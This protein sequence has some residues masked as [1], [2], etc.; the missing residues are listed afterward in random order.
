MLRDLLVH[1]DGSP[2]GRRRARFALELGTRMG[3]QLTG[4]HVT[5][6]AEAP[7][8]YKPSVVVT[9]VVEIARRLALDAAEA[10]TIFQE[11]I[12]PHMPGA[13]WIAGNGDVVDGVCAQARYSDLVI[14]GQYEEEGSPERHPLPVAHSIVV[15]CGRPVLVIPA[16]SETCTFAKVAIA[17]DRGR[18]AV[19]AVHD[20]LPLLGLAHSVD[21]VTVIDPTAAS[22]QLSDKQLAQHLAHHGINIVEDGRHVA[23]PDEHRTLRH[24]LVQGGYDLLVMGGYSHSMW[25]EF[26]FGGATQSILLSS[27][28]PVLVSH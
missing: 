5:P 24:E 25:R 2:A 7:P 20:A 1:I 12:T 15:R 16:G 23:T 8:V 6:P 27:K 14:V 10:E 22:D 19:R 13:R 11:E 17:W 4:L 18:E 28:T 3:A 26:I 9:A 21:I